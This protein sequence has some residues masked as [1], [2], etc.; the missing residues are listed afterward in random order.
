MANGGDDKFERLI[1]YYNRVITFMRS[2]G[3][4]RE[5]ARDLTQEVFLRVYQNVDKYRGDAR[6]AY[7]QTTARNVVYNAIRDLHAQKR[8]GIH[9]SDEALTTMPD[10]R[11]DP[12]D[13]RTVHG[14][15][16]DRLY[17]AVER[18]DVRERPCV[19]LYLDGM[20]YEEIGKSLNV[21]V[22]TV[23]SRLNQARKRLREMLDEDLEGFG[24]GDDQ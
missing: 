20:S 21:G 4:S 22:S 23:K 9:V 5:D 14:E 13:V 10:D 15:E 1:P 17:R 11:V 24:D 6:W 12:A 2:R 19:R 16:L 3:F 7:L 18:L 8:E